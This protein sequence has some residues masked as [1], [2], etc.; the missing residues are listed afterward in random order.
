M[1]AWLDALN[2]AA[3]GPEGLADAAWTPLLR[4][5]LRHDDWLSE[6]H[7]RGAEA[8][9]PLLEHAFPGL[10]V[11]QRPPKRAARLQIKYLRAAPDIDFK[12]VSDL[13][14]ARVHITDV[15]RTADGVYPLKAHAAA[16]VDAARAA[17]GRA[18]TMDFG[19]SISERVYVLLPGA[20]IAE[21]SIGH[22][23]SAHVF[24]CDSA[25]RDA[26]DAAKGFLVQNCRA[27]DNAETAAGAAA[28]AECAALAARPTTDYW[29]I[30]KAVQKALLDG[31]PELA[32][33]LLA[34]AGL[35]CDLL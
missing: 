10:A 14:A 9:M 5:L 23:F 28:C 27:H 25:R 31:R 2:T 24:A 22:P 35:D 30:W 32:R 18:F 4:E 21:I 20:P 13:W 11:Q 26:A 29:G 33:E 16:L 8:Y 1:D 15:A 34:A 7:A 12:C 6:L 3:F 17:G 19:P